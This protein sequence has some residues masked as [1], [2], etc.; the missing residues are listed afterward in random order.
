[1]IQS[2]VSTLVGV[3]VPISVPVLCGVVL[4]RFRNLD[5][6]PLLTIVLYIL[7]P[8]IIFKTLLHAR[9]TLADLSGVLLFTAA[10]IMLLWLTAKLAA[11]LL[12]LSEPESAGLTLVSTLTN[13]VNYGLPLVLLAFG[14]AGLEK[15]SV[16]IVLMMIITHTLGI[17]LAARSRFSGRNALKSVFTLPAAY[18]ALGAILLRW[19]GFQLPDGVAAGLEMLSAAYAPMVLM[20]LGAQMVGVKSIGAAIDGR[21]AFL[22]GMIIR[23]VLSPLIAL[24]ILSLLRIDGL[25]RA[26]L[27][28]L[29]SMPVAVNSVILADRFDAAA[30]TVSKTILWSTLLSFALLPFLIVWVSG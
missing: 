17:Y 8:A 2:V 13:C 4:A 14:Q 21:R 23:M 11:R 6:K 28:I 25:L 3:I 29:A 20:V 27:F 9:I 22:A 12:R 7:S 19:T 30:G 26:V 1:M 10:N 16:Y 24:A 15:A 18:A 5:T